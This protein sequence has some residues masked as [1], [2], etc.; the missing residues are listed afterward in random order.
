MQLL[1]AQPR[2]ADARSARPIR[3]S[4]QVSVLLMLVMLGAFGFTGQ[5]QCG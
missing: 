2:T 1:L 3:A 5:G 4:W